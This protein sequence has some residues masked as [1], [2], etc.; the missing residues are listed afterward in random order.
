M[1]DQVEV[2]P[3]GLWPAAREATVMFGGKTFE[4]IPIIRIEWTP[5]NL[6]VRRDTYEK[7]VV[8]LNEIPPPENQEPIILPV[9]LSPAD[10]PVD[11]QRNVGWPSGSV[12]LFMGQG[13]SE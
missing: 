8:I 11:V 13:S 1:V 12:V 10:L 7:G 9:Q 3:D 2:H 6:T 5:A 4:N